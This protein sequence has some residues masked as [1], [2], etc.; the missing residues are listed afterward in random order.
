MGTGSLGIGTKE[1]AAA[2]AEEEEETKA[3]E[4]EKDGRSGVVRRGRNDAGPCSGLVV[5]APFIQMDRTE[6][7]RRTASSFLTVS[8][9]EIRI[10]I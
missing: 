8:N 10:S 4:T 6:D 2:V 1:T 9:Q 7:T 5:P 3:G